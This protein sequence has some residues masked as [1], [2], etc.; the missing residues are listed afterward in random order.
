MQYSQA[1][2]DLMRYGTD[3]GGNVHDVDYTD[4]CEDCGEGNE[5]CEC[6]SICDQ[7]DCEVCEC[8]E[9]NNA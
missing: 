9:R 5:W 3:G 8:E 4:T 7:C 2:M 6:A 1:E